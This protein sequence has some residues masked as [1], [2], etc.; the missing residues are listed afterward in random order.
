MP[1]A[2]IVFGNET[3]AATYA[4]VMGLNTTDVGEI[5]KAG[6]DANLK[7]VLGLGDRL[8]VANRARNKFSDRSMERST[9]FL[10]NYDQQNNL[11]NQQ[12]YMRAYR[13]VTL[14]IRIM[15]SV[16]IKYCVFP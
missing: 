4:E 16:F 3:E 5:A 1:Y 7:Y 11:T 8:L 9:A 12:T 15:Y 13:E 2:D 10:G 14:P 6:R